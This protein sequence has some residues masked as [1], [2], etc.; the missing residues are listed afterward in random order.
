MRCF[1]ESSRCATGGG[2]MISAIIYLLAALIA[3][4][5]VSVFIVALVGLNNIDE[6][7]GYS[8]G[9]IKRNP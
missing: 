5:V 9:E 7:G 3:G 2:A 6:T 4:L 8:S 1:N